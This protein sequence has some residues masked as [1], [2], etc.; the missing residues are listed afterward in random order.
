MLVDIAGKYGVFVYDAPQIETCLLEL[1][2]KQL[3][4]YEVEKLKHFLLNNMIERQDEK[5]HIYLLISCV[6]EELQNRTNREAAD[7]KTI[8]MQ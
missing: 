6:N 7:G 2:N 5:I 8:N 1:C 4:K 3:L